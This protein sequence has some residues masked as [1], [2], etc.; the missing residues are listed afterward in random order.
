MSP[1][2]NAAQ[3]QLQSSTSKPHSRQQR[4]QYDDDDRNTTSTTE[5]EHQCWSRRGTDLYVHNSDPVVTRRMSARKAAMSSMYVLPWRITSSIQ[6]LCRSSAMDSSSRFQ[7]TATATT[8]FTHS[9][10]HLRRLRPGTLALWNVLKGT[11]VSASPL[12]QTSKVA[13]FTDWYQNF[14]GYYNSPMQHMSSVRRVNL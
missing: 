10:R 1:N 5:D 11:Q 8:T 13:Q 2:V 4:W 14:T 9:R 3:R 12:K 7:S 6:R